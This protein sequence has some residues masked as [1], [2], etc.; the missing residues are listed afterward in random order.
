MKAVVLEKPC[1]ANDLKVSEVPKPKIKPGTVLVKIKAFGI[2]RSE[3]FTRQGFSPSVKLPRIMGIECV[4]VVEDPGDSNFLKGDKVISMM[5]GLGRQFDGSY[6]EYTLIPK[7]Q[8]YSIQTDLDFTTLAAIPEMYYTAYASL[9]NALQLKSGETLLIRGGTSSVGIASI[10]LA[11]ALGV[12]TIATTRNK[13]KVELLK[14][15]GADE[16][17][18]DEGILNCSKKVDKIQELIGTKTLK[19]SL[20]NVKQ[21]RIVCMT[22]ILGGEW[23]FNSF[24]PMEDIP[25]EVYLTS[26][27]SE[28]IKQQV[29]DNLLKFIG[30]HSI[31]PIISK[32]F[33]L[34]E[35]SHAHELM[36]SNSSNGKI[37]VEV[38]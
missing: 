27:D 6:A 35:I 29:I 3:I 33:R 30:E 15:L 24:L 28:V 4:G 26:F 2:N 13:S 22:G 36:E 23:E 5:G 18:I 9:F 32:V 1:L 17:I 37:V 7:N 12:Y 34:N 19:D 14:Q 31:K 10:Q 21:G 38:D 16:V 11:K 8:V 20:K 25:S